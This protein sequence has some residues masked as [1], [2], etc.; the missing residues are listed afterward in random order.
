MIYENKLSK[1]LSKDAK[2][3]NHFKIFSFQVVD[4]DVFLFT[5]VTQELLHWSQNSYTSIFVKNSANF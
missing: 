4:F 3:W 2:E 1:N 5:N